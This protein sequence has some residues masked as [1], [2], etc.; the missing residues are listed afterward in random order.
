M[1]HQATSDHGAHT[2]GWTSNGKRR[3]LLARTIRRCL[4]SAVRHSSPLMPQRLYMQ[5]LTRI[6]RSYGMAIEGSPIYIAPTV[7]FDGGDYALIRIGDSCVISSHV[8]FLTHDYSIARVRDAIA[9]RRITPELAF[10]RPITIGDNCFIGR[11]AIIMPGA[12]I[13]SNSIIGAGAVVRGSIPPDSLAVGNP[14]VVVDSAS[15]WGRR[16]LAKLTEAAS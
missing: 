5:Y 1:N 6:L 10:L 8:S 4:L 3:R 12:T 13:G 9:Q 2:A 15:D 16:H 7:F 11:S 14:A